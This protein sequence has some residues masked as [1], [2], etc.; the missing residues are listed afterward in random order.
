MM[1]SQ[2]TKLALFLTI[3][4]CA[5][6]ESAAPRA[7]LPPSAAQPEG[8]GAGIAASAPNHPPGTLRIEL[9]VSDTRTV[10]VQ[11]WYPAEESARAAAEAGRP[12]VE[13]EPPGSSQRET[14]E[15]IT[16][17]APATY[18]LRTM[19]AADAPAVRAQP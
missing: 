1:I 18:E 3:A 13:F 15:R 7:V 8:A 11:L 2:S 17:Q 5:C 12:V 10:P 9:R 16:R 6:T 19:H 4:L 14:L